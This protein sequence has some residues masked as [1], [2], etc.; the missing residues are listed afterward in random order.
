MFSPHYSSLIQIGLSKLISSTVPKDC[1]AEILISVDACAYTTGMVQE[2]QG[3]ICFTPLDT[4]KAL[5]I[6]GATEASTGK[7]T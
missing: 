1:F 3:S 4:G 5:G 7:Q 6:Q 2:V